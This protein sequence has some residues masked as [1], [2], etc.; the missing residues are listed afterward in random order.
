MKTKAHPPPLQ[1]CLILSLKSQN[2]SKR[3]NQKVIRQWPVTYIC[4]SA[5]FPLSS[6]IKTADSTSISHSSGLPTWGNLRGGWVWYMHHPSSSQTF[7]DKI[8]KLLHIKLNM[9]YT[10]VTLQQNSRKATT[11]SNFFSLEPETLKLLSASCILAKL[12]FVLKLYIEASVSD[13]YSHPAV[14]L[15]NSQSK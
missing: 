13:W 8:A 15:L 5:P 3:M 7:Q 12:E 1:H 14:S 11:I 4:S 9:N 6:V 2:I 10:S